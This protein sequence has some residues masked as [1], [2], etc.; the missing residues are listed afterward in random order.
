MLSK[1]N[2]DKEWGGKITHGRLQQPK[3]S[4]AHDKKDI[5]K[6]LPPNDKKI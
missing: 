5:R 3:P 6:E 2:E 1:P 4:K